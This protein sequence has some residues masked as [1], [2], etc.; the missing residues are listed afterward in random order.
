MTILSIGEILW[1]VYPDSKRLGGAPFNFAV[2]AHRLGH[3]VLFL[4][5]VGDDES[6]AAA[7]EK[8]E[9]LGLDT[10]FIQVARG[11]TTGQV[12]VRLDSAGQPDY[13]I[14]RPAAY[15]FLKFDDAQLARISLLQPDWLYFGT[16]YQM[17]TGGHRE[18]RRLVEALPATRRFYDV[19]LRRA[20]YTPELV[21]DSFA[22]A[23]AVKINH[24]EAA[25]F[26]DFGGAWAAAVTAGERGSEIRIGEDRARCP[27][28]PVKVADAVGAGDAFAAAFVHGIGQ[29]WSA[30][31]TG[32]FANRLGALVASRVG[33]V[34][35]WSMTELEGLK[36]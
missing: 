15:D 26:P 34:P 8:A 16:L 1:D 21:R 17:H 29:G 4:S 27:A 25:L 36:A 32:D 24:D 35:K 11:K 12:T 33:A 3:R 31:R 14:H 5:A 20:S 13:T 2:H 19:N 22:L 7:R 30:A 10:E 23:H 6:G 18:L 28:Y 9:M